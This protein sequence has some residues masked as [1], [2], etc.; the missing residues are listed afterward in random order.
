MV[1]L[2]LEHSMPETK[3]HCEEIGN[4]QYYNEKICSSCPKMETWPPGQNRK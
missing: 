3:L 1:G 4:S 2:V